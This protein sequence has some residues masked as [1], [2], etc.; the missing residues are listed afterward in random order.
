MCHVAQGNTGRDMVKSVDVYGVLAPW[1]ILYYS[2][3]HFMVVT[4]FEVSSR[5]GDIRECVTIIVLNSY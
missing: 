2:K 4:Q 1:Y 5:T 3:E